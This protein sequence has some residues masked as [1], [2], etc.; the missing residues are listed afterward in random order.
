MFIFYLFIFCP[1]LNYFPKFQKIQFNKLSFCLH[2]VKCK[3]N[4]VHVI[5]QFSYIRPI[6][7]TLLRVTTSGHSR[8]GSDWNE[9]VLHIPYNPRVLDPHRQFV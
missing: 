8:P 7:R 1:R 2:T 3:N 5:T 6:D 9:G 4:S